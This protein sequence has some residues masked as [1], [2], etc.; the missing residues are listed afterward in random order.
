MIPAPR[1]MRVAMI[2]PRTMKAVLVGLREGLDPWVLV[3]IPDSFRG[4]ECWLDVER[5]DEWW[6]WDEL[7]ALDGWTWTLVYEGMAE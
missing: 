4:D 3:R 2:E 5:Y 7:M 6:A 1:A